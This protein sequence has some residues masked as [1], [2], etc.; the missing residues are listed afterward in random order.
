MCYKGKEAFTLNTKPGCRSI[1]PPQYVMTPETREP[2]PCTPASKANRHY[3]RGGRQ[4]PN[5]E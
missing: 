3:C 4:S 1:D 2:I 5:T